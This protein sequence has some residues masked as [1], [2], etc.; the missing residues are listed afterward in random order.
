MEPAIWL[1][2]RS[3]ASDVSGICP[4]DATHAK[5]A[6]PCRHLYF[7]PYLKTRLLDIQSVDQPNFRML[8]LPSFIGPLSTPSL[9]RYD[10]E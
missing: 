4:D 8:H 3:L 2:S 9:C 5:A 6:I 1:C 10:Q 7:N